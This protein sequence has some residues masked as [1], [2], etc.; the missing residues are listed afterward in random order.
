MF[1]VGWNLAVTVP[2]RNSIG[3]AISDHAPTE[4]P[5]FEKVSTVPI[6]DRNPA[7]PFSMSYPCVLCDGTVWHMWYGTDLQ[8]GSTRA[9]AIHAIRYARSLDGYRWDPQPTVAVAPCPPE[10]LAVCRP[11]VVKD[12]TG[13]RMWFAHRGSEYRLGYAESADGV[14]WSRRDA[15]AGLDVSASGWDA[16]AVTYPSVF[17]LQGQRYLLYNGN[18]YGRSGFGVAVWVDCE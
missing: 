14:N 9:Q 18:G 5:R 8:T 3:L 17:D 12:P 4:A 13:F 16:E 7:D 1:Y 11:S 6:L 10:E 15:A 2:W